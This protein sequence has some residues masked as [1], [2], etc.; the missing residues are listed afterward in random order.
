M[1][2]LAGVIGRRTNRG[3]GCGLLLRLAVWSAS[4][5]GV[6]V[7][8]GLHLEIPRNFFGNCLIHVDGWCEL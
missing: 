5:C 4:W 7:R 6:V 8:M 2:W 3:A 1:K